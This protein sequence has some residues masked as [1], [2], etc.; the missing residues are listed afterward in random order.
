M[1]LEMPRSRPARIALIAVVALGGFAA[2]Y[3][4]TGSVI[5]TLAWATAVSAVVML[6]PYR[7]SGAT[8]NITSV[9][10]GEPYS[11]TERGRAKVSVDQVTRED[12]TEAWVVF[13]VLLTLPLAAAVLAIVAGVS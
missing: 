9:L 5:V 12:R 13:G 7:A 1:A 2:V 3:A 11:L 4:L 8:T 10:A 6:V